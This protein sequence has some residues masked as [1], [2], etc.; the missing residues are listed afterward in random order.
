[1]LFVVNN[2]KYADSVFLCNRFDVS[3]QIQ[4]SATTYFV[5]LGKMTMHAANLHHSCAAIGLT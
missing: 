4:T 5:D 1:M 3:M 2:A